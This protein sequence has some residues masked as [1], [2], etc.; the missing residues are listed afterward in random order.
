MFKYLSMRNP[1][2]RS[3]GNSRRRAE[4]IFG[5]ARDVADT[6]KLE[7]KRIEKSEDKGSAHPSPPRSRIFREEFFSGKPI[8]G[9]RAEGGAKARRSREAGCAAMFSLDSYRFAILSGVPSSH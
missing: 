4:E 2:F 9:E 6:G 7:K 1:S 8:G 3:V 5:K